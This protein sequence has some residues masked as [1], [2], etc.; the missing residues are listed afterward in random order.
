MRSGDAALKAGCA[1]REDRPHAGGARARRRSASPGGGLRHDC[2]Q[3][4]A[5]LRTRRPSGHPGGSAKRGNPLRGGGQGHRGSVASAGSGGGGHP[6]EFSG[7]RGHAS[8]GKR[9]GSRQAGRES[10]ACL[11]GLGGR[12]ERADPGT[13]GHAASRYDFRLPRGRPDP[14]ERGARG[15]KLIRSRGRPAPLGGCRT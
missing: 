12:A 10:A 1:G 14:P 5:R 6:R 9:G 13:T 3:P 2:K 4:H 8:P 11:H 7:V 15:E